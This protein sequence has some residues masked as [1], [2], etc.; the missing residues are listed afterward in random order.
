VN[1]PPRALL[2]AVLV[3]V[4]AIA[5]AALAARPGLVPGPAERVDADHGGALTPEIRSA[6]FRFGADVAPADQQW[7][8]AAVA[9]TRPEAR[10]LIDAVDGMIEVHGIASDGR[11][12]GVAGS[13][14]DHYY[15]NLD[16]D[17]LRALGPKL[18]DH[19]VV[20]ELGHVID[21]AL[22]P[23]AVN[24]QLDQGIP[25]LE[26]CTGQGSDGGCAIPEER[27][28]DTFAKWAL[29]DAV[30]PVA[31]S[32][33]AGYRVPPPNNLVGWAEPLVA[34]PG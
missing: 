23:Q 3:V 34:L 5:G 10:R 18:R 22:V 29:N 28:A 7:I 17:T 16:L 19:V 27:F 4:L 20:H 15:V 2:V 12:A 21:F 1:V 11:T 31:G 26:T 33:A 13:I 25:R 6:T 9:A 14:G 32:L 8:L 24:N 30:G